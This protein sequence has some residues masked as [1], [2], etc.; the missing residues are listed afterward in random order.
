MKIIDSHIHILKKE[1]YNKEAIKVFESL[2]NPDILDKLDE[3]M[4]PGSLANYLRSQGI[5]YAV[6]LAEHAPITTGYLPSEFVAD[7]CRGYDIF[8]P[9]ASINPNTDPSPQDKLEYYIKELGMKGLKLLPSYQYFYPNDNNLYVI[10]KKACDLDIPI[11]FHI[12]SSKFKGTR[13]K[14]AEPIYLDDVAV[15]FPDLKIIMAHSGR[16]FNYDAAFFLSRHHKNIYMD[17]TGLP[18][19]RLLHYFPEL[20]KNADKII[21]GSDW[22]AM[23][24]SIS[25]NIKELQSLPLKSSTIEK[26]LY[27]NAER[28]L[29]K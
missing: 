9:F 21:F 13:M 27:K 8:I 26:I 19:H 22:P 18:P 12:G 25:E 28:V 29:L 16:G 14:Y 17:I 15:D 1:Y 5:T 24:K 2:A 11:I 4:A 20:E 7:F 23:T 3:L 10:Y 6:I